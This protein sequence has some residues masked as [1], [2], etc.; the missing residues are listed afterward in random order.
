MTRLATRVKTYP[1]MDSSPVTDDRL[2]VDLILGIMK[3]PT[4]HP[5]E[6]RNLGMKNGTVDLL[7]VALA[8]GLAERSSHEV[9]PPISPERQ[10]VD[11][12][13]NLGS[14]GV[15]SLFLLLTGLPR[16]V[17]GTRADEPLAAGWGVRVFQ[18]LD[19]I[20]EF[21]VATNEQRPEEDQGDHPSSGRVR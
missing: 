7:R 4:I 10:L 21:E 1:Q 19:G 16:F 5:L 12:I 14:E 8:A 18:D 2:S 20:P 6:V 11:L 17:V 15:G 9:G 3:L 13:W